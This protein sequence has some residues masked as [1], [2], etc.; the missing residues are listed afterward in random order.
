MRFDWSTSVFHSAINCEN[1]VN[2]MVGCLQVVKIIQF[3]E[4]IKVYMRT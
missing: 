4:K 1:D 3:P 2:N